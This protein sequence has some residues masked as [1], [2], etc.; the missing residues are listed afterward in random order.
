[1]A[2]IVLLLNVAIE[3]PLALI[4]VVKISDG[5]SQATCENANVVGGVRRSAP[6]EVSSLKIHD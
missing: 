2:L 3:T 5:T 4:L 6:S 1:M